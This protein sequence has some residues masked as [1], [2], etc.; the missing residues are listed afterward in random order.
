MA[1]AHINSGQG[2]L[3]RRGAD[4]VLTLPGNADGS[5]VIYTWESESGHGTLCGHNEYTAAPSLPPK[6]YRTQRISGSYGRCQW[7]NA[8][9]CSA[10]G[11]GGYVL[12]AYREYRGQWIFSPTN[13]ADSNGQQEISFGVQAAPA[14]PGPTGVTGTVTVNK[15]RAAGVSGGDF[16]P[17]VN[18]PGAIDETTTKTKYT[19]Q[20]TGICGPTATPVGR[21]HGTIISE[22]VDED[23]EYDAAAR[24]AG[25]TPGTSGT[26]A[27]Q[28]R[29]AGVFGF[30][31]VVVAYTFACSGLKAGKKYRIGF[32][33]FTEDY[34]G[35][36]GVTSKG[37][38]DFVATGAEQSIT[39]LID[40][41]SGK[42]VTWSSPTIARV[43]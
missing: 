7:N 11:A 1:A 38:V 20:G 12:G 16:P 42:R 4:L 6:K 27:F 39:D 18:L 24:A 19:W 14:C 40:C 3:Q 37:G 26:A 9:N 22:L 2:L 15:P 41:P 43:K 21:Y 8:G 30:D 17:L 13:C 28:P 31:F 36:G 35:G 10:A 32:S 25:T 29:A 23:T 34:A 33:V 5:S